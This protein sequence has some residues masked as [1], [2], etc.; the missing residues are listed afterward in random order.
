MLMALQSMAEQCAEASGKVALGRSYDFWHADD[1][2]TQLTAIRP[3]TRA[4]KP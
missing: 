2:H 3:H 1:A 4:Q